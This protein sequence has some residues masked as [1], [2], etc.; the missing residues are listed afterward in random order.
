MNRLWSAR[1]LQQ[2]KKNG[3]IFFKKSRIT[4]LKLSWSP[5]NFKSVTK[6]IASATNVTISD[7]VIGRRQFYQNC[8]AIAAAR[9]TF[10]Q[11]ST[12]RKWVHLLCN[13]PKTT[14][15]DSRMA[16]GNKQFRS[17][18]LCLVSRVASLMARH[19]KVNGAEPMIR[20]QSLLRLTE[21]RTRSQRLRT[22]NWNHHTSMPRA[23]I[24]SQCPHSLLSLTSVIVC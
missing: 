23:S 20:Q 17:V 12:K 10:R 8:R 2:T 3:T 24:P 9:L 15:H 6:P 19:S 14:I 4:F 18:A 13:F 5:C 7:D 16:R 11:T 21:Q 1:N 22:G